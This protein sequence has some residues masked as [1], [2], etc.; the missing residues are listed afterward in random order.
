MLIHHGANLSA[1]DLLAHHNPDLQ[2]LNVWAWHRH[3]RLGEPKRVGD[4]PPIAEHRKLGESDDSS[5]RRKPGNPDRRPQVDRISLSCSHRIP[6]IAVVVCMVWVPGNLTKCAPSADPTPCR[7]DLDRPIAVKTWTFGLRVTWP[8]TARCGSTLQTEISQGMI[9]K[10]S[11]QTEL[12]GNVRRVRMCNSWPS[13]TRRID[14]YPVQAPEWSKANSS[15]PFIQL[16]LTTNN[17]KPM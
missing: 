13:Q 2:P 5:L 12:P 3:Q 16:F 14:E 15:H 10:A 9:G 7:V 6:M 4:G 1:K 11:L 17:S 8:G